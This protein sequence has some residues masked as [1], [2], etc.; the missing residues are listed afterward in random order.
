MALIGTTGLKKVKISEVI[1]R[2]KRALYEALNW[3]S[4]RIRIRASNKFLPTPAEY[5]QFIWLHAQAPKPEP[6]FYGAERLE[7]VLERIIEVHLMTYL[8][9]D[10]V[11]NEEQLLL[12]ASLGHYETEDQIIDILDQRHLLSTA[13]D[14][15]ITIEPLKYIAPFARDKELPFAVTKPYE[16]AWDKWVESTIPYRVL[17]SRDIDSRDVEII[18]EI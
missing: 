1:T 2:F 16:E 15:S 10:Q 6:D 8:H 17:Y 9:L 13:E 11:D 12:D 7:L 4:E 18:N 5:S 14:K 3:E